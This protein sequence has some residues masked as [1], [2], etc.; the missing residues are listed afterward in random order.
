MLLVTNYSCNNSSGSD[1][2]PVRVYFW[3]NSDAATNHQLYID[4]SIKGVLPYLPDSVRPLTDTVLKQTALHYLK[5]GRY[6]LTARDSSGNVLCKG[7]L[8]IKIG[9][10]STSVK[11]DWDNS[12]CHVHVVFVN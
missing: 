7:M 4:D 8:S 9:R 11:T 12:R 2:P 10:G 1:H 3:K 5:P 6:D